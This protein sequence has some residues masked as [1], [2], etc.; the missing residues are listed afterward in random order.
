[1]KALA[2]R[3]DAAVRD[4]ALLGDGMRL[5]VPARGLKQ[6]GNDELSAG[7][8]FVHRFQITDCEQRKRRQHGGVDGF[9]V[10]AAAAADFDAAILPLFVGR[11]GDE[12]FAVFAAVDARVGRQ[13]PRRGTERAPQGAVAVDDF[14]HR[15]PRAAGGAVAV[16][17]PVQR[18]RQR[19]VGL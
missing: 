4:R 14:R 1:M 7:I 18:V 8:G 9:Q 3:N 15:R 16:M 17:P 2:H 5:V 12:R 6:L 11:S 19:I 13:L 10:P